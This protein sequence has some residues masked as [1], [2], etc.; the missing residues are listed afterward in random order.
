[1]SQG[2]GLVKGLETRN[3]EE[4]VRSNYED[5]TLF[6]YFTLLYFT[7]NYKDMFLNF[8]LYRN[9]LKLLFQLDYMH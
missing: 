6:F 2:L 7:F 5:G 4:S 1:M 8:L 9:V 3:Q